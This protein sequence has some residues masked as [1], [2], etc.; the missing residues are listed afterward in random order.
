MNRSVVEVAQELLSFSTINSKRLVDISFFLICLYKVK[1]AL[2]EEFDFVFGKCLGKLF[3]FD[4]L[5]LFRILHE[6]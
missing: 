1:N 2:L 6:P 4:G 5:Y 3:A